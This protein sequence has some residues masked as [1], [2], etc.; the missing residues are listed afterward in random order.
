MSALALDVADLPRDVDALIAI[1]IEQRQQYA[2]VL[3]SLRDQLSKLRQM[4]FGSRSERLIGQALLFAENVPIPPALPKAPTTH[5]AAHDRVRRG[6]PALAADLPHVR[7]DYD[8][9]EEQKAGFD[10]LVR[11]GEVVSSTLDVIPQKVF[12]IDHVRAKYR[13]MKD[14]TISIVVAD[15]QPSPIP[16]SNAS[17]GMLAH[18]LVSK[19]ADGLPLNRQQKIFARHGIDLSRTTLCDWNLGSTEKLAVLMPAL[20]TH[21]LAAQVL[22]ADDTT[23]KLV[24][25]GR[26]TTR[27]A[28]LWAYV[29]DGASQDGDGRWRNYPR[30]AYFEFTTT[31]EAIHPTRFLK[32]Y[33]GYLQ[34]DDYNGYHPTFRQGRVAHCLCWAHA[35]RYYFD[36]ASRPGA[37]P[38]A[39]EALRF[40]SRIY[41]IEAQ[42]KQVM[43]DQRRLARQA[44]TVPLLA[45][46]RHWLDAHYPSLLPRSALGQAFG[47]TLSNWDALLRFTDEGILAPDSNLVE[48]AIRPI[49][50]GRKA[51]LFAGSERGGQAAAVAFSLIESC[52][53]AG[54]EP[55]AYL[56][57][58]LQRLDSHRMDRLHELLPFNWKPTREL[59]PV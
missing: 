15:A 46:F 48:R 29:S 10:R 55:Y 34:A 47:Y 14:G 4:S 24:E 51:W 44:Q 35:R 28:R 18:V 58:V 43:P 56:R 2:A 8:L 27:T 13:A 26:R 32:T 42:L 49:A 39:H 33:R 16:K 54:V 5:V 12:V 1:V 57:D 30:A 19:Y 7:K 36:V 50:V 20:K 6:R 23:L 22:F 52:K 17:A 11:I 9:T 3:E 40:I 59:Y 41:E 45:Q 53:L 25:E 21:V 37:S 31:R 38:L